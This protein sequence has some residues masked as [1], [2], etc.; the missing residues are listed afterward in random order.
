ME[1]ASEGPVR[2]TKATVDAAWRRRRP[3]LRL[4]IRDAECRGIALVVNPTGMTWTVSYKPRGVDAVTGKRPATRE[5][6]LG[7][8][9][10]H[11]PEQ[12]RAMSRS[13]LRKRRRR[14]PP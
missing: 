10:T 3:G 14:C 2:I 4:T 8:P 12:A 13:M 6:T 5:V 7:S 9:A 11:S 1:R